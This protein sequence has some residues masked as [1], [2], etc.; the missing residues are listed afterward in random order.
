MKMKTKYALTIAAALPLSVLALTASA[1]STK[2]KLPNQQHEQILIAETPPDSVNME[3]LSG[4]NL[5][6]AKKGTFQLSFDQ[7]LKE[8]AVLEIKN[9]AGKLVYQKPVMLAKNT[10]MWS[11]NV[12]KLKPDTYLVEVKTS[13][14]TYWT[15][16]KIGN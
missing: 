14:T 12:G 5:K 10:N 1:Q 4:I 6:P 9:K 2:T 13:D 8:D 16:F 11:Y 7:K 3:T 15:K